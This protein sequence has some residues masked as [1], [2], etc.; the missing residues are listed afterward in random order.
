MTDVLRSKT[1]RAFMEKL[2][3]LAGKLWITER[4]K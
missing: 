2:E 3:I 1:D 4:E